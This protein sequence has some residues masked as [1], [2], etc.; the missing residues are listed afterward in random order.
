VATRKV[1]PAR[2]CKRTGN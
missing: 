1:G 2:T